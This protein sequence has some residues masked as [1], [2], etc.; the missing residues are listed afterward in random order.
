MLAI[1]ATLGFALVLAVALL[2]AA[3]S[4]TEIR[5]YSRRFDR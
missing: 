3:A 2:F 4:W 5:R 1:L